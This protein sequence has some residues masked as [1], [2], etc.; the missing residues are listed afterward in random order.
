MKL[1]R[2][3]HL[4]RNVTLAA[5]GA[6]ALALGGAAAW[7][8]YS[9]HVAD[10]QRPLRPAIDA[11]RRTMRTALGQAM[12]FYVDYRSG[13]RPLVLLHSLNAAASAYEVKPLFEA[14]AGRRPV[15]APDLPGFGF[16]E[17][18]GQKFT[19]EVYLSA[20]V[21]MLL[22]VRDQWG[23]ADVVALS[24]TSELAA[25]AALLRKDLVHSLTLISP[26]GLSSVLA[27]GHAPDR[28]ARKGDS[29]RVERILEQ[30]VWAQAI[31]AALSSR[32]SIR[33]FLGKSF[34]G[35]VD[36]GL[37][38]Y[39][40]DTSHQPNAR[41]APL[42]FVSGKLFTPD[43]RETVY[44]G[45]RVPVLV[46]Y[47]TDPYVGFD[48]LPALIE[49]NPRWRA[50]R[51]RPSRGLPHFEQLDATTAALD[52]FFHQPTSVAAEV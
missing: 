23:P 39:A 16:S 22:R 18:S 43:V 10:R 19:R 6:G 49:R 51:I 30:P 48:T 5:T 42:A 32:P 50:V 25:M 46:L 8:A 4:L 24:L 44:L 34:V 36:P 9:A 33:Y 35:P 37:A 29:D 17:R 41:F 14:Y 26:T 7:L 3:H 15:Y 13:G 27:S 2:P 45:L 20:I 21:D 40:Y 47:D 12:S 31:F 11:E 28:R 1:K 38:A 52:V